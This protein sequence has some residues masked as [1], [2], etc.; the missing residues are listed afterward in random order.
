MQALGRRKQG[1]RHAT[2]VCLKGERHA[3]RV[4]LKANGRR[5]SGEAFEYVCVQMRA[6]LNQL[7]WCVQLILF[8]HRVGERCARQTDVGISFGTTIGPLFP[9][10]EPLARLH[11][12]GALTHVLAPLQVYSGTKEQNHH[13]AP[14]VVQWTVSLRC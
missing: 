10:V 11:A 2:H 12:D 13:R 8:T 7:F 4:C 3:T 6:T 1:E 14:P 9:S 5:W